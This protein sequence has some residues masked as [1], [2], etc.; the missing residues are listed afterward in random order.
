MTRSSPPSAPSSCRCS[1]LAI[2]PLVA[3]ADYIS[4]HAAPHPDTEHSGGMVRWL[5]VMKPTAASCGNC[6]RGA[7]SMSRPWRRALEAGHQSPALPLMF[8]PK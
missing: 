1:L 5:Q 4:L 3:E 8:T 6:A 2:K 7:S